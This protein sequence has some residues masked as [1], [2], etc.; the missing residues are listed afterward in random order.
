MPGGKKGLRKDSTP[1]K[2]PHKVIVS[3]KEYDQILADTVK[4]VVKNLKEKGLY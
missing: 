2:R 1:S 3:P 4:S